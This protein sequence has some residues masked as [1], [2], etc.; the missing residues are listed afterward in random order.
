VHGFAGQQYLSYFGGKL[1]LHPKEK[2]SCLGA[3]D[4][5]GIWIMREMIK[6]K[7]PGLYVFHRGEEVGC[8]GSK[9]IAKHAP[10]MAEGIK[11]AIAF[12]RR[13]TNSI[14]TRQWRGRCC[15]D[16]FAD[17]LSKAIGLGHKKDTGGSVT[18]TAQYMDLVGECTNVSVGYD[19]EHSNY[20]SLDLKYLEE[21]RDAMLQFDHTLLDYVRKPGEADYSKYYTA[22]DYG[23]YGDYGPTHNNRRHSKAL[24]TG[25]IPA[26]TSKDG[27]IIHVPDG[28]WMKDENG[29][30]FKQYREPSPRQAT[31][32]GYGW[33]EPEEKAE[34]ERALLFQLI[35]DNPDEIADLLEDYGLGAEEVADYVFAK[36]GAIPPAMLGRT[37]D[38]DNGDEANPHG[39]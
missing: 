19:H 5:A 37:H 2:S 12:D 24:T 10:Q 25:F 8:I 36:G 9:W 38:P 35:E 4:G 16:A 11:A 22:Y 20:E 1:R 26:T 17:S 23:D 14:I 32:S 33:E 29:E 3:D 18:D 13:G 27:K 34:R 15:S 30:W 39:E 7:H 21:L 6:A 28:I 31:L